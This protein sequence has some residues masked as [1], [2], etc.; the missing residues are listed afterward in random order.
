MT[1]AGLPTLTADNYRKFFIDHDTP[2]VWVGHR[3]VTAATPA[4]GTTAEFTNASFDG[5]VTVDP[6]VTSI[7]RF[8]YHTTL[9]RWETSRTSNG[10][11][12]F[13]PLSFNTIFTT[14]VGDTSPIWLGEQPDDETAIGLIDTFVDTSTYYYYHQ[15]S[16]TIR[17]LD[18]TTYTDATGRMVNY[19][20]EPISSSTGIGTGTITDIITPSVGGLSGGTSSGAATLSLN[21][22]GLNVFQTT[23]INTADSFVV[24]DTSSSTEPYSSINLGRLVGHIAGNTTTLS[25][26]D[27]RMSVADGGIT[28]TQLAD[29]AITEPKLFATNAPADG[30]ILSYAG[31]TDVNFTW[32]DATGGGGGTNDYVDTAALTISALDLTLT[33]GRTGT[34]A[35]LTSTLGLPDP[36]MAD[37]SLRTNMS[38][39]SISQQRHI[40]LPRCKRIF[41]CKP[42]ADRRKPC[43]FHGEQHIAFRRQRRS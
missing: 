43:H 14:T 11:F 25:E 29:A 35:D 33:L 41:K 24:R 16:D 40:F 1:N 4:G 31:G 39:T 37:F 9:H 12:F 28:V 10:T 26:S 38:S 36:T 32:I 3:E 15:A 13:L 19:G 7:G 5:A 17:L 2:R 20:A 21:F 42:K 27:G 8:I 6:V 18:N 34:L 22:D 23:E 30:Q